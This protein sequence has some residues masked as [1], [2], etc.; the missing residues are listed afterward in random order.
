MFSWLW[1]YFRYGPELTHLTEKLVPSEERAD[2]CALVAPE[3]VTM[4]IDWI[5]DDAKEPI[6]P[7]APLIVAKHV[8]ATPVLSVP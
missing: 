1:F 3:F 6:G 5:E 2:G 8:E 4:V 7:V